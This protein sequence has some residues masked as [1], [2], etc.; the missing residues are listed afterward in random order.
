M[1]I[2]LV[3]LGATDVPDWEF[4][5]SIAAPAT[6]SGIQES[7]RRL[8]SEAAPGWWLLWDES[9]GEPEPENLFRALG[10]PGDIK[11]AGLL[12][13]LC[14][15]PRLLGFV[16]PLWMLNLDPPD[17]AAATS[18]RVSFRAC[19]LKS[20]VPDRAGF[21]SLK[22]ETLDACS[23][24]YGHV[25]LHAGIIAR[26]SPSLLAGK[27]R[28]SPVTL[29]LIDQLEFIADRYGRRWACWAA[30]RCLSRGRT[31]PIVL[32]TALPS[33]LRR[34]R[35]QSEPVRPPEPGV[36]VQVSSPLPTVSVLI[37]TLD[38]YSY[39][40]Q[41]LKQLR[42]QRHSPMEILIIDQTAAADREVHLA[43]EYPDLPLRIF[44]LDEPGQCT[45]RNVGLSQAAGDFVLF[46]DDDDEVDESLVERHLANLAAM[47]A[48]VSSGI[49]RETGAEESDSFPTIRRTSDIFPTNNSLA[50]LEM[51]RSVGG[52]DPVYDKG[53]RADHDLG[54]RLYL[55]GALM[56][57]DPSIKVHHHHAP[58]GGLRSHGARTTTQ[59]SSRLRIGHRN[60]PT[61]SDLY[62]GLK[63][64]SPEQ[65][66]ES[67]L[68]SL[69]ATLRLRGPLHK[70]VLK[71]LISIAF[72][73]R[74]VSLVRTRLRA[75]EVLLDS[76]PV[77]H[78]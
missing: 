45:A 46:L 54:M 66:S 13:G 77:N 23:L 55:S 29:P 33:V 25:A 69:F 71:A 63:Y 9:L 65:V 75:A 58:R 37:P 18:W 15:S 5:T 39:L 78:K 32:T 72:L 16:S 27:L 30:M 70:R 59:S 57:L 17:D 35:R 6:P 12:L 44:Q 76:D 61:V 73:P 14:Q 47:S 1:L 64:Y 20:T 24:H 43:E 36:L 28:R 19:L 48:H 41:L 26:F 42:T 40:R 50:A 68:I 21:P 52:F 8:R 38:R 34:S 2:H 51:V 53:Q 4:G 49:V 74:S 22:F 67:I 62:L 31:N 60:L 56:I 7:L 11:H 10:E 3:W